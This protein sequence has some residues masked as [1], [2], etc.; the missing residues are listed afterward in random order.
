MIQIATIGYTPEVVK[1]G[2]VKEVPTKLYIIH[3]ENEGTKPEQQVKTNSEKLQ[4]EIKN[5]FGIIVELRKVEKYDSEGVI[6]TILD[7]VSKEKKESKLENKDFAIN[8]TGGTK[9][10]VAGAACAAYLAQT[11]M[12]Y[13]LHPSEANGQDLVREL[14][15]PSRAENANG[16]KTDR[17]SSAVLEKISKLSPTNNSNLLEKLS[18]VEITIQ[19]IRPGDKPIIKHTKFTGQK[20]SYHLKRL[21]EKGLITITKGWAY[22]KDNRRK[23]NRTNTITVT[24]TGKY[25]AEYPDLLG[26]VA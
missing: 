5:Q 24:E 16:G 10:M 19:K 14:P 8:I 17:T 11:K 2:L 3:T 9:A 1:T 15:V 6:R 7:I 12:Y 23:N 4:K 18:D 20:L 21:E 22:G 13:V 26:E 25:Y